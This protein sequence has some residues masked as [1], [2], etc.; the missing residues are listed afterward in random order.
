MRLIIKTLKTNKSHFILKV[1]V[2]SDSLAYKT[3]YT[4]RN[5]TGVTPVEYYQM[6]DGGQDLVNGLDLIPRETDDFHGVGH[7]FKLCPVIDGRLEGGQKMVGV[8]HNRDWGPNSHPGCSITIQT[9]QLGRVRL[10]WATFIWP[11]TLM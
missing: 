8:S 5:R 3:G 6:Q 7:S 2:L 1:T 9:H 11:P 4:G 10:F